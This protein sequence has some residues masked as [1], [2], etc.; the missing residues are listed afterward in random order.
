MQGP[1]EK[2]DE[3]RWRVN[4]K[5]RQSTDEKVKSKS[6]KWEIGPMRREQGTVQSD[7]WTGKASLLAGSKMIAVM[8]KS[9]WWNQYVRFLTKEL[10]FSLIVSVRTTGLDIYSLVE[11]ALKPTISVSA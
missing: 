5:A 2:E 11:V 7:R 4:K 3:F 1:Q 9:G 6:F 10:S 8:P